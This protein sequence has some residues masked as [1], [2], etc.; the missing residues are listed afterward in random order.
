[1][2]QA[3]GSA[4]RYLVKWQGLPYG[5]ATWEGPEDL[6]RIGAGHA[7][8]EFLAREARGVE[9]RRTVDAARRAFAESGQRAFAQQPT[10]LQGDGTLRDYQLEGLNWM[11]YSWAQ[12]TN[13]ILADE[14]GLGKTVQCASMIGYLAETQHIGG[15][16]IIIVPLSVVPNWAREFRKWLP[17]VRA[18][19]A[20][21]AA[22]ASSPAERA[23]VGIVA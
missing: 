6:E 20:P 9:P 21:C 11:V 3:A 2:G 22:G 12:G 14:M 15:P 10:Y 13:G 17:Q 18:L 5:E 4:A 23:A 8:A 1:M 7:L 16:F 19:H